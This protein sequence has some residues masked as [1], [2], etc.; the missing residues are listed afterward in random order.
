MKK[1]Y[2]VFICFILAVFLSA[3]GEQKRS[4]NSIIY[5]THVILSTLNHHITD[6]ASDGIPISNVMEGLMTFDDEGKIV[7]GTAQSYTV[8]KDGLIYTFK[9][10]SN[11]KWS[12][13][14]KVKA[15]DFEWAWKLLAKTQEAP[16]RYQMISYLKN[17]I[18]VLDGKADIST[19]GVKAQDEETL[20]VVLEKPIPYFLSCLVFSAMFPMNQKVYEQ[21]GN[22]YG[23]THNRAVYNGPFVISDWKIDQRWTYSKNPY[24]WDKDSVKIDEIFVSVI[25]DPQ[26]LRNAFAAGESDILNPETGNGKQSIDVLSKEPQKY[27]RI[28]FNEAVIEYIYLSPSIEP[29]KQILSNKHLRKALSRAFNKEELIDKVFGNG[30]KAADYFIPYNFTWIA[31]QDFRDFSGR[32]NKPSSFNID[33]AKKELALAKQDLGGL[34][35]EIAISIQSSQGSKLEWEYIKHQIESN[36]DGVKI[37]LRAAPANQLY[38]EMSEFTVSAGQMLWSPDF[39]DPTTFLDL[40]KSDSPQNYGQYKSPQYDR[41]LN[42]ADAPAMLTNPKAR[43]ALLAKAEELLLDDAVIIPIQ[44]RTK[45]VFTKTNISGIVFTNI[46][47]NVFFKFARRN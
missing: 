42:E 6:K 28:N 13:G 36:L 3:C 47:A 24:Y 25:S 17:G 45:T 8:S 18:A 15:D 22:E 44:Q 40:F 46:G 14:D 39:S 37:I 2:F 20:I 16:Y 30:S 32:F 26:S 23:T 43:W 4:E 1:V 35:L 19:L 34:P 5:A 12:N 21:F 27:K 41:L 7:N 9:I 29:S 31:R 10:R 38:D 11:A 33:E